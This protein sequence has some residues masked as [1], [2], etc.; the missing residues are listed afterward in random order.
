MKERDIDNR[1]GSLLVH[2]F[3][4]S[5]H[6]VC[7]CDKQCKCREDWTGDDC[8][9]TTKNDTCLVNN[10]REDSFFLAATLSS[11]SIL[12]RLFVT[13]KVFAS[14]DDVNATKTPDTLDPIAKIVQYVILISSVFA[15]PLSQSLGMRT[16]MCGNERLCPL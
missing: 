5:D 14:V 6:G 13:I 3:P 8:S 11:Y 16:S 15:C 4:G 2:A 7:D 1:L 10:V 9:C 12:F